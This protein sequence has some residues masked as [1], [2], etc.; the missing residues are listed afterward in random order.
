MRVEGRG[1]SLCFG[2]HHILGLKG[3]DNA[4]CTASL[5]V[6]SKDGGLFLNGVLSR[7]GE[8]VHPSLSTHTVPAA[9]RSPTR[10]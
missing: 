5:A 3:L 8:C 4:L 9:P 6:W 7:T 1:S 2:A 10:V